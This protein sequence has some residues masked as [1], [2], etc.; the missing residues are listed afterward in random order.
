M[1]PHTFGILGSSYL[2]AKVKISYKRT[3]KKKQDKTR[4]DTMISFLR[5]LHANYPYRHISERLSGEKKVP[6]NMHS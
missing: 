5:L 6:I 4:Q 2:K 1:Y 3:E